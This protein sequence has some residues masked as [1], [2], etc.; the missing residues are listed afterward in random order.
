MVKASSEPGK[1]AKFTVYLPATQVTQDENVPEPAE[2]RR[3]I[4][5]H[6][7]LVEDETAVRTLGVTMLRC[8]GYRVTDFADGRSALAAFTA[9]PEAYDLVLTDYEM[10]ELTGS[11]L[12]R[13]IKEIRKGT[14]VVL[15][16][17]YS[18]LAAQDG[19]TRPAV[20]RV[21]A[22]PYQLSALDTVIRDALGAAAVP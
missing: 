2:A 19:A 4:D 9:D 5:A 10:P 16:T 18:H 11:L 6:V 3:A 1:G 13:R 7:L 14:P 22:K 17:G 15:L 12:A 8:L 21:L 20:D